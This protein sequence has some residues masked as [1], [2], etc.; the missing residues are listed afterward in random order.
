MLKL[1]AHKNTKSNVLY[2]GYFLY[3]VNICMASK[4]ALNRLLHV[5]LMNLWP[6]VLRKFLIKTVR[7][8]EILKHVK[9]TILQIFTHQSPPSL[10][11]HCK[12]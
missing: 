1:S 11:M 2:Q 12:N 9:S 10:I 7:L 3:L 6:L 5:L 8:L 4:F